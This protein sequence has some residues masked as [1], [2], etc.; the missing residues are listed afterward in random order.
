MKC[1]VVLLALSAV[2]AAWRGP[3][4]KFLSSGGD[5]TI[6]AEEWE[7]A[8]KPLFLTPL[9]EAGKVKVILCMRSGMW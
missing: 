5:L 1:F 6:P 9:L 7:D 4:R 8:G 2:T 3:F